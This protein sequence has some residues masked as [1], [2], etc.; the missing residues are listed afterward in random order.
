MTDGIV[1]KSKNVF[2]LP[3]MSSGS[4]QNYNVEFVASNIVTTGTHLIEITIQEG[5][6]GEN[7][8][9]QYM[10]VSID[11][12]EKKDDEDEDEEENAKGKPKVIIGT[13]KVDPV[14]VKAGEEF[15]LKIGFLNTN[16]KQSV[17]NFKANITINESGE[18][19]TGSVFTPVNASNTFFIDEM[20]PG[21]L[22][23][24]N[25]TLY[26]IPSAKP[27][28]Y[29]ITLEMDYEDEKGVAI[30][31]TEKIGIPV[32][33]VTKLEVSDVQVDLVD[34][35][36]EAYMTAKI[37]NTGKTA[38][39]NV[40]ITTR[41]EGFDVRDN[42]MFIGLLEKGATENYE[43]T[44]I[45]YQGGLLSGQIHVEYE[46]VAGIVQ[47]VIHDFDMEVNEMWVMP[48]GGEEFNPM[49]DNLD[50]EAIERNPWPL[51]IGTIIGLLLAVGVTTFIL[52]KRQNKL[53]ENNF[54]E[55]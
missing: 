15:E 43:P 19:N 8:L 22:V 4:N 46:D 14:I 39:S 41:G 5:N 31:E 26:T 34:V 6:D 53:D 38:I 21:E 12:P 45:P 55:D 3:K 35:G 9:K 20:A 48:D 47:S 11:N 33:Q 7:V 51:V 28:T 10:T 24:K 54:D 25:I 50:M 36:M 2:T 29:E 37:Y 13:Y 16:N 40:K 44:I 52:K 32:E 17:H 27:K 42:M 30:M 1:P 49:P 18:N 23:T